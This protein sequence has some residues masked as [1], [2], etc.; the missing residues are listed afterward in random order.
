MN[1][2]WQL[3]DESAQLVDAQTITL[4]VPTFGAQA[5]AETW[6][7]GTWEDLLEQGVDSVNLFD[8]DRLIYG[9]MSLN[10]QA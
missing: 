6:I 5:D 8:G 10:A 3:L 2:S 4:E 7:G 1:W 9:P